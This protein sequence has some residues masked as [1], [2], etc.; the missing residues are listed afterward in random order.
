MRCS[1]GATDLLQ[2]CP[3]GSDLTLP[4]RSFLRLNTSPVAQLGKR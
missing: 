2:T 1:M 4:E 3:G